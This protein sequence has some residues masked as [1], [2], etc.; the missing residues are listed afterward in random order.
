M[1]TVY[2]SITNPKGTACR[3]CEEALQGTDRV[4]NFG[5]AHYIHK[6]C[7]TTHGVKREGLTSCRVC[8]FNGFGEPSKGE[9]TRRTM[10]IGDVAMLVGLARGDGGPKGMNVF[11][12]LWH[13]AVRLR[14][15]VP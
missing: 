13:S 3:I 10:K 6:S 4:Y 12:L 2:S 11:P 7:A 5:C 14:D 15:D 1:L 9:E 8:K